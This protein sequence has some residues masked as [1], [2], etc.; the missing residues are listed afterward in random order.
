MLRYPKFLD[1]ASEA[2]LSN[3]A[4]MVGQATQGLM[5]DGSKEATQLLVAALE[6]Q[7]Q[8]YAVNQICNALGNMG[9]PAAKTALLK[10]RDSDNQQRKQAA[11][12][13]LQN[14]FQRSPGFQY[15]WQAYEHMRHHKWNEAIQFYEMSLEIDPELPEALAGRGLARR[16]LGKAE[17]AAKDLEKAYEVDPYNRLA[18]P[19]IALIRVQAGKLDDGLKILTAGKDRYQHDPVFLY[20]SAAVYAHAFDQAQ[21]QKELPERDKRIEEYRGK[22]VSELQ[23]AMSRGWGEVEVI[24]NDPDFKILKDD[25]EFKK[26]IGNRPMPKQDADQPADAVQVE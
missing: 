17:E 16:G 22:V 11:I 26:L 2:I 10:A 6:K 5:Q 25:P 1:L 19:G 20:Y 21:K 9:D 15:I 4:S 7:T 13:A 23:L 14:L 8:Q 12:N 3:D 24:R 18:I